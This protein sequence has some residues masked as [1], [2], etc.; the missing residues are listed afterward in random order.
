MNEKPYSPLRKKALMCLTFAIL[1][2][3]GNDALPANN[4][5]VIIKR[6]PTKFHVKMTLSLSKN[7]Y[8]FTGVDNYKI[9]LLSP[10]PTTNDYH[11]VSKVVCNKG[12]IVK[13]DNDD[14]HILV[15]VGKNGLPD[16][17]RL[18]YDIT[19]YRVH[20]DFSK[21]G[22]VYP[23]DTSSE[24]YKRFTAKSEP[25][26]SDH[27]R[28]KQMADAAKRISKNDLE[29]AR[30]AFIAL[31]K[32]LKWKTTGKYGNVTEIFNNGGGDCAALTTI[33]VSLMRCKGVPARH[34]VGGSINQKVE[35]GTHVWPEFYLERY[36]WI[37]VDPSMTS[38]VPYF[39]YFDGW[40]LG[41]YRGG[42]F[43]YTIDGE[44]KKT[45]W[46][47]THSKYT[48]YSGRA[49]KGSYAYSTKF[50]IKLLSPSNIG[51]AYNAKESSGRRI[52]S[53]LQAANAERK[54]R[55]IP[56]FASPEN[57]NEA[58]HQLV[59]A[60]ARNKKDADIW[61][62]MARQRYFASSLYCSWVALSDAD[63]NLTPH[64]MK[65]LKGVKQL[66]DP[67]MTEIGIGY[68]YDE[69][70][71]SNHYM[72]ALVAP[73]DR[74]KASAKD[75]GA[76]VGETFTY[77]CPGG[78]EGGS[79]WGS[80]TYTADSSICAAARHAGVIGPKGGRVRVTVKPGLSSYEGSE[81]N[82]VK[83]GK[84]GAFEK[85]VVVSKD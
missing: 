67:A 21:I 56:E 17:I 16:D 50:D 15:N 14:Q 51:E 20:V 25:V 58:L 7:N 63:I 41:F 64:V 45:N 2:I 9:W 49:P 37:P 5:N 31:Q 4:R 35:F 62:E 8:D 69:K 34:I 47:Q 46:V 81:R 11:D 75:M 57:L 79:L 42:D 40:A 33:F 29:Y 73:K 22:T 78:C 54:T 13:F 3:A 36:G 52:K 83:S 80:D 10:V 39:G 74:C 71:G 32:A 65:S 55:G 23:Y 76:A 12:T 53:I 70:S 38:D 6:F 18:E 77:N 19:V 43:T 30:N 85:S 72:I 1:L 24:L 28:I 82:G 66:L 59:I 27:P 26:E 61:K 48:W 44:Q 84:W 68:H 60:K